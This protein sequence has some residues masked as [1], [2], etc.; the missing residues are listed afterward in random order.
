MQDKELEEGKLLKVL[1]GLLNKPGS[2]DPMKSGF[3]RFT[4]IK[5]VSLVEELKRVCSHE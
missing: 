1:G 2:L 4:Q 3:E 5:T